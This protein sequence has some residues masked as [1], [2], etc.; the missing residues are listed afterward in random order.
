M[1]LVDCCCPT[2]ASVSAAVACPAVA[3]VVCQCHRHFCHRQN[4]CPYSFCRRCRHHRHRCFCRRHHFLSD[5]T[6]CRQRIRRVDT[7]SVSATAAPLPLSPMP[8]PPPFLPRQPP[9]PKISSLQ[10]GWRQQRMVTA[11][12]M[13]KSVE[14]G[15]STLDN[16]YLF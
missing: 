3:A 14:S 8:L 7:P 10:V 11:D 12:T 2:A 6:D 1:N 16:I 5:S 4:Q 9:L 13:V 15:R